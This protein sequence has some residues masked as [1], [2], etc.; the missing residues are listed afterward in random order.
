MVPRAATVVEDSIVVSEQLCQLSPAAAGLNQ[1][2]QL[3]SVHK[4][5]FSAISASITLK[6]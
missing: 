4:W 1:F 5:P 2:C 6:T 3:V